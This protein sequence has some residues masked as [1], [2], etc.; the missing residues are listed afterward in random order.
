MCYKWVVLFEQNYYMRPRYTTNKYA[1]FVWK[2]SLNNGKSCFTLSFSCNDRY[3]M[4]LAAPKLA[5]Y[6]Y[7]NGVEWTWTTVFIVVFIKHIRPFNIN[8][9]V[10]VCLSSNPLSI[11]SLS[12]ANEFLENPCEQLWKVLSLSLR[13]SLSLFLPRYEYTN[14]PKPQ[15]TTHMTQQ[16]GGENWKIKPRWYCNPDNGNVYMCQSILILTALFASNCEIIDV[17]SGG[18]KRS[19]LE[20]TF[21]HA[22]DRWDKLRVTQI[23]FRIFSET[24]L[25]P[26]SFFFSAIKLY[27]WFYR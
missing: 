27:I 18:Q 5:T 9:Y 2:N 7:T 25:F 8:T 4:E 11:H 15:H 10:C 12:V 20:P 21:V 26:F 1:I 3:K 23:F 17:R 16:C 6:A 13:V 14:T 19:T 22:Y 24:D